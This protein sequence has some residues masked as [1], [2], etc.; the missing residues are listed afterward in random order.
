M[1]TL[2]LNWIYQ[3]VNSELILSIFKG[4][5]FL[6]NKGMF[7]IGLIA[8]LIGF[9]KTRKLGILLL[10]GLLIEFLIVDVCLKPMVALPRPCMV[11]PSLS[12]IPCLS[13][14]SFPSGHSGMSFMLAG[15]FWFTRNPYRLWALIFACFMAFSRLVLYVHW[16]SDVLVGIVLG[17]TIAYGTIAF[18]HQKHISMLLDRLCHNKEKE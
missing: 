18:S 3:L 11:I 7:F 1:E 15:I 12:R 14:Y 4:I 8:I 5:T 17:W 13:D 16:P 2:V 9:R 10:V 6:G